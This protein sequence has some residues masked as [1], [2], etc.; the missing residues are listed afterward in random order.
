MSS[1][2][3][4]NNLSVRPTGYRVSVPNNDIARLMY[5]LSCVDT[6]IN[7][8]KQDIITDYQNYDLLTE[9]ERN[10][11]INLVILFNPKMFVDAGIFILDPNLVPYDM[12]NQ[13]YE[14]TDHRIGFN[15]NRQI[16]FGGRNVRVLKVMACTSDWLTRNYINPLKNIIPPKPTPPPPPPIKYYKSD[17][18]KCCCLI[19]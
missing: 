8:G 2:L 16:M 19:F 15:V 11:L 17:D 1:A 4:Y 6:V 7:Y 13:F 18:D 5:Y 12:D 3:K 10:E 14:I 9:S